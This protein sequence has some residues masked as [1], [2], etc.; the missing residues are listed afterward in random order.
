MNIFNWRDEKIANLNKAKL[1]PI[2]ENINNQKLLV[3]YTSVGELHAIL[4]N[5]S[6]Y[7]LLTKGEYKGDILVFGD[8]YFINHNEHN[9]KVIKV[10]QESYHPC[11]L[12]VFYSE[13]IDV[14]K[15]DQIMYLDS[16]IEVINN[17]YSM[18]TAKDNLLC[19]EES[20]GVR[21]SFPRDYATAS[22]GFTDE[23]FKQYGKKKV[24]NSGQFCIDAKLF[25][26]FI[27]E[28]KKLAL[29]HPL[30]W[31]SDQSSLNLLICRNLISTKL[32]D[33]GLVQILNF[34][35]EKKSS[36]MIHFI[37]EN[38]NIMLAKYNKQSFLDNVKKYY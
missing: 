7:S 2:I 12:R 6:I 35:T 33:I 29:E 17:I 31:G 18:F 20:W 4:T 9:V 36:V 27:S 16:D 21:E 24:I 5:I 1:A 28:W 19:V 34:Y 8:D 11:N 3:Y 10:K 14:E 15:Y 38:K 37:C 30:V 32:F 25:R 22:Y 23:E 13:Q 26:Q